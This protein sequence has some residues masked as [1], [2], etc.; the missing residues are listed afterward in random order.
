MTMSLL[1]QSTDDVGSTVLNIVY[2]FHKDGKPLKKPFQA[3]VTM[4]KT[5][6]TEDAKLEDYVTITQDTNSGFKLSVHNA[7]GQDVYTLEDFLYSEYYS[8]ISQVAHT[9]PEV[10]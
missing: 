7:G 6:L 10:R 8:R 9:S 1:D 5:R 4:N 3:P 2:D